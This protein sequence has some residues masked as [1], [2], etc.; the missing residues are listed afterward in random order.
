MCKL[1]GW[2]ST[3]KNPL[4][5]PAA[6]RALLAAHR[7]ISK[8]ESD[9]FGFAQ[10]GSK[11]LH[12]R[13]EQP[14]DFRGIDA[15][16]DITRRAGPAFDAFSAFWGA[17]QSGHYKPAKPTMI[18]GRTATHGQGLENTHP[19]RHSGWTLAHNGV[20][21]WSGADSELHRKATCDSQHLLYC[22]TES[23]TIDDARDALGNVTGYAA[24]IAHAPNG[25]MIVAKDATA[26]LFAGITTKGRWIFG[27]TA[28]ICEEVADAM[29]CRRFEAF[30]LDDWV[31]LDFP[32]NSDRPSV[33]SWTHKA[34]TA[35]EWGHAS[36]SLGSTYTGPRPNG[37]TPPAAAT[38]DRF[39]DFDPEQGAW[40]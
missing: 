29:R 33:E 21:N 31:W 26:S 3:T 13:F 10:P 4:P 6:E 1:S 37:Y 38:T 9:G 25:R 32:P 8:T 7:K 11:G 16:A 17:D 27:T 22:F 28:A 34:T 39:P 36:R 12:A 2:T 23:P 40:S 14:D 5:K 20:V 19:F 30:R 24:F 18:H 15:L 35:R